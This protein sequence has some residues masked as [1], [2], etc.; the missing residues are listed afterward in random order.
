MCGSGIL[1][2]VMSNSAEGRNRFCV[3]QKEARIQ[4]HVQ[5]GAHPRL[6]YSFI[7]NPWNSGSVQG[8]ERTRDIDEFYLCAGVMARAYE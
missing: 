7:M 4:F 2:N 6:I 8:R 5:A 1:E 3:Q